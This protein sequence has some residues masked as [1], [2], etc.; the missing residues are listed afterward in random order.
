MLG[1]WDKRGFKA[2]W[3]DTIGVY[4]DLNVNNKT[5]DESENSRQ[6]PHSLDSMTIDYASTSDGERITYYYLVERMPRELQMTFKDDI[7][8]SMPLGVRVNFYTKVRPHI[9]DW[10]SPSMRSRL[11]VLQQVGKDNDGANINAYNLHDN[12]TS[13]GKQD[14]IEESLVYLSVADRRRKRKLLKMSM[15]ITLSGVRGE[16]FDESVKKFLALMK[17][18]EIMI[19]R[20][21]YNIPDILKHFSPFSKREVKGIN[22]KVPTQVVTDELLARLSSYTQG[23]LGN[24]GISFGIDIYRYAPVLKVVKPKDDS[25]ENWLITA[26][27]GGGKSLTV[28]D[29]VFQL[30]ALNF[31][32]TIMDIEGFEYIP[33]ANYVS[34]NSKVIVV[35]MAEGSG[36][37]FD[38]VE[39]ADKTGIADIDLE[40]YRMSLNF[41]LS[42]F[43]TLL[44]TAY[45]KDE[46]LDTVINDAV[47]NMYEKAG[48]TSDID[49]WENS[50][51]YTLFDVYDEIKKLKSDSFREEKRYLSAV[52]QAIAI[53]SRYF[54]PN[55][56]QSSVFK[57]RVYVNDIIDANLVIC[58]FGM[59][60]KSPQT[61]DATQLALMQLGAAHLSHQRSIYSKA[62]GKYNFKLWEEFQRWGKFPDSEKTIGV[63]ITGGRKLGDVNIILTND[64]GQILK[65][66]IFSILPNI[67][68]Y[69]IGAISDAQ[70]RE[71]LCNRLSI[72][73]MLPELD[74]IARSKKDD[75]DEEDSE[76][77]LDE[78]TYSFLAGLDRSKFGIVKTILPP[79]IAE[80]PIFKTGVDLKGNIK[81][82][83]ENVKE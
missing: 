80:S 22:S 63:A 71:E 50:R 6:A 78:Y 15:L 73:H 25:A 28:K 54:E 64:I 44:G 66:D 1:L 58:S 27:T 60:G 19:T 12:L 51:G 37:Y 30:L 13:L 43:K 18:K 46:W 14:W 56:T 75:T 4:D 3:K 59:A 38:P 2:Y 69:M 35:N 23:T 33:L 10:T 48:V 81:S 7:R 26:E 29:K 42:Y 55:G 82:S 76:V 70:V 67:S 83:S 61:V 17:G 72:P 62:Q 53:T 8:S 24:R 36:N 49:T 79:D 9:I 34:H 5:K 45:T 16:Q 20:V 32:G 68:S 41:T 65:D 31:N 52:E 74:R 39:I 21:M 47:A 77:V 40:A 57:N 11:K